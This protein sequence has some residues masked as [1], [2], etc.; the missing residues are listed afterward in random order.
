MIAESFRILKDKGVLRICTPDLRA[1]LETYFSENS[2]S[3][4]FVEDMMCNWIAKG[5]GNAKHY[6]P[7]QDKNISFFIN[8]IFNNYEHKF[9][10]DFSTL[11]HL[12]REAGF[13]DIYRSNAGFSQY[14]EL[15]NIESHTKSFE[16]P[17]TLAIEAIK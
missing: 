3:N 12:L 11:E 9:I 16:L 2:S 4:L 5:F 10:Y 13:R 17:Y 14:P 1:Y 8:D 7:G 15:N 6:S